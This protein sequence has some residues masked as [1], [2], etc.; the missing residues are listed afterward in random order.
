MTR[1][2]PSV[3]FCSARQRAAMGSYSLPRPATG[4]ARPAANAAKSTAC[5]GESGLLSIAS[6]AT[7]PVSKRFSCT[8]MAAPGASM[9][10]R[11]AGWVTRSCS[12]AKM[13]WAC[14]T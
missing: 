12:R 6:A 4:S 8:A 14:C 11:S 9:L 1:I 13:S 2:M 10:S 3:G 5:L 7:R